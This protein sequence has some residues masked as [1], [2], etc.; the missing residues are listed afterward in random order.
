MIRQHGD[1]LVGQG[2]PHSS[3]SQ[4]RIEMAVV[5]P[6]A[7]G[8]WREVTAP[9]GYYGGATYHGTMQFV[10]DPSGRRMRGMWIG[11]GRDFIINSGHWEIIRQDVSVTK[12]TQRRYHEKV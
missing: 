10:I 3:G 11:F 9:E 6:I 8:S 4:L 5:A 1:R 7:T 12:T 2:L